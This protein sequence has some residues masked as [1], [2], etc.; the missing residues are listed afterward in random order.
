MFLQVKKPFPEAIIVIDARWDTV[1]AKAKKILNLL[2]GGGGSS[3]SGG[4][5]GT[6]ASSPRGPKDQCGEISGGS[7]DAT[8]DSGKGQLPLCDPALSLR[9]VRI[10]KVG[11]ETKGVR[12]W[13]ELVPTLTQPMT[14]KVG[15]V[16]KRVN[17]L[18]RHE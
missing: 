2:I 18:C 7:W 8:V 1:G 17:I 10:R 3:S 16:M 9:P 6:G 5:G 14:V 13:G 15:A 4:D 12:I 11:Q